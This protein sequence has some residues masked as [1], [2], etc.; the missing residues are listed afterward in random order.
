MVIFSAALPQ[1]LARYDVVAEVVPARGTFVVRY[2]DG[3]EREVATPS[4]PSSG[5]S[6]SLHEPEQLA[7]DIAAWLPGGAP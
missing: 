2:Q 1:A 5:H 6:I 4:Y 7:D 3:A